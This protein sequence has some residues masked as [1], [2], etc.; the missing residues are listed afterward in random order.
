MDFEALL[1]FT[2]VVKHKSFSA[3]AVQLSY[4]QSTV[5]H[6][7]AVLERAVGQRLLVRSA[8]GAYPTRAGA[9]LLPFACHLLETLEQARIEVGGSMCP[10]RGGPGTSIDRPRSPGGPGG[11]QGRARTMS[12]RASTTVLPDTVRE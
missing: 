12:G 11:R 2:M 8:A 1:A 10:H 3:A 7:I 4:A 5:S 9:A 6:R